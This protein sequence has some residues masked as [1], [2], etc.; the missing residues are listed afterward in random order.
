[1]RVKCGSTQR[2]FLIT[3]KNGSILNAGLAKDMLTGSKLDRYK[4][5]SK[6]NGTSMIFL[7]KHALGE[8][9]VL[10]LHWNVRYKLNE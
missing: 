1:L 5:S 2:T 9:I 4:E 7:Y 10:F 3:G 8:W 6:T